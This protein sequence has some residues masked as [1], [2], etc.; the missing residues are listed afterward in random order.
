MTELP[1]DNLKDLDMFKGRNEVLRL[2]GEEFR[3]KDSDLLDEI[4]NQL[5]KLLPLGWTNQKQT[6]SNVIHTT[7]TIQY[8]VHLQTYENHTALG[9]VIRPGSDSVC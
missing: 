8:V 7:T 5:A 1:N 9:S 4:S 2:R 6:F 3:V